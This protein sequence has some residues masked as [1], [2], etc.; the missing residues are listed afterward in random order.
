M[1]ARL[2]AEHVERRGRAC[3]ADHS[4]GAGPAAHGGRLWRGHRP[5]HRVGRWAGMILKLL[6]FNGPRG[7]LRGRQ[8]AAR[9]PRVFLSPRVPLRACF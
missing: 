2:E 7:E 9:S 1:A 6:V 3:L 5:G 4:P 8:Q